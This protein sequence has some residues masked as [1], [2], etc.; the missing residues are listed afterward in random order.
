MLGT[1]SY[2]IFVET[3]FIIFFNLTNNV[4]KTRPGLNTYRTYKLWLD[5]LIL[6]RNNM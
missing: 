1:G 2:V 3:I 5:F 4:K 6:Q